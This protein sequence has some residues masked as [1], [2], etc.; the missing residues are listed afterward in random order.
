VER[1]ITDP[2]STKYSEYFINSFIHF[3]F[4]RQ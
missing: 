2:P 4:L 3:P 1:L